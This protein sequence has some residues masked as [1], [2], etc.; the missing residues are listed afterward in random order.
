MTEF[1]YNAVDE[2][3]KVRSG[4]LTAP[5]LV[6]ARHALRRQA[7]LPVRIVATSA[8]SRG[9][10]GAATGKR[11]R[12]AIGAKTLTL[13]TRQL[14]SLVS[15]AIRLEE[16]FAA[17]ARQDLPGRVKAVL[18]EVRNQ[19]IDGRSLADALSAQGSAFPRQY[20]SSVA[21]GEASGRLDIVLEHLAD[22]TETRQEN[23]QTLQL[24]LI[25]PAFLALVSGAVIMLLLT[26]VVPDVVAVYQRRGTDLPISTE[27]L[28]G[29]SGFLRH[30]GGIM[31]LS[32]VLTYAGMIWTLRHPAGRRL[33]GRWSLKAPLLGPF[34]RRRQAAEVSST[35]AILIQSGVP[36]V[37]ALRTAAGVASNDHVADRIRM[38]ASEVA[39]GMALDQALARTG[40]VPPMMLAIVTSAVRSGELGP[41]LGRTSRDQ[42]KELA[43]QT[44]ALVALMEPMVLLVMG[45]I[46]LFIVM[47]ILTPIVSLNTLSGV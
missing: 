33:W 26:K 30:F 40:V 4:I 13:I 41:A 8:E 45:S 36:L 7:L 25:Y 6:E 19:I 34:T 27:L 11:G 22:Y 2:A 1:R 31:L 18:G 21:A 43:A 28:I 44:K 38:A 24:A 17:I 10:H 15:N 37:H 32:L 9:L 35:L 46:V 12:R 39:E 20:I 5:S 42:Q 3:G 16:A 29:M 14:A 23:R 47:A